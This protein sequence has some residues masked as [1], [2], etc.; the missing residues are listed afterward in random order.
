MKASIVGLVLLSG[1]LAVLS[2][3]MSADAPPASAESKNI[4]TLVTKAAAE[5][6]KRGAAAYTDFRKKGSGWFQGDTYL[7]AYN[8]D[9]V[10][11]LNPAF[12][13][14]EGTKGTGRARSATNPQ[15]F[16]EAFIEMAKTKGA[17]WVDYMY[18][19]PGQTTPSQKWSY[20][21]KVTIDGTPGLV[22]AGFYPK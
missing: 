6:D 16:S 3:A 2:P 21:H 9:G 14:N 11:L 22:G 17:G 20:V 4:E 10:V 8:L 15:P 5:I 1:F 12:P 19:K 7:F 18:P 13:E